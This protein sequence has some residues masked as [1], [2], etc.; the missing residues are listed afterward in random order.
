MTFDRVGNV[1]GE[2]PEDHAYF[3]ERLTHLLSLL[4]ALSLQ[5]LRGDWH[6]DNLV[7]HDPSLGPPP[8]VGGVG[9]GEKGGGH[10]GVW[11]MVGL[12]EGA[13]GMDEGSCENVQLLPYHTYIHALPMLYSHVPHSSTLSPCSP[14]ALSYAFPMLFPI[15]SLYHVF[16]H[17]LPT[18]VSHL[19][20]RRMLLAYLIVVTLHS[21]PTS[22]CEVHQKQQSCTT[23]VYL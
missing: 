9:G 8:V 19:C 12:G 17:A 1:R 23:G 18:H 16:T 7:P 15:L 20:S 6:L 5:H 21:C 22:C 10:D 11:C 3:V 13:L 14:Y 4:H 2:T